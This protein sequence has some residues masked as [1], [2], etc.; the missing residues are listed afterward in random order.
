MSSSRYLGCVGF[1][2]SPN[3]VEPWCRSVVVASTTRGGRPI[4]VC[5]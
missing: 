3:P 1:P 2:G 4:L 5:L